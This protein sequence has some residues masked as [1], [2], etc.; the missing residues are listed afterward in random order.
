MA[1]V[2]DVFFFFFLWIHHPRVTRMVWMF[3]YILI[4]ASLLSRICFR[5]P[6]SIPYRLRRL[7][8]RS[9]V[10]SWTT[11]SLWCGIGAMSV[12]CILPEL[13]NAVRRLSACVTRSRRNF[14]DFVKFD[15]IN[16]QKKC[17][18]YSAF[19][20]ANICDTHN[21]RIQGSHSGSNQSSKVE[22]FHSINVT[23]TKPGQ[24]TAMNHRQTTRT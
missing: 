1:Y 2:H 22:Y 13:I 10:M 9:R 24:P 5:S 6:L 15:A 16:R 11:A 17:S 12:E 7:Y 19:S 18:C 20:S 3:V 8:A 23:G 4:F 14:N 21:I